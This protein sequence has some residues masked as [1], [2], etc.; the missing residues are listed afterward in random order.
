MSY[1]LIFFCSP[2]I[3]A[4]EVLC[5]E[6]TAAGLSLLV[7]HGDS[8]LKHL[9]PFFALRWNSAFPA[10]HFYPCYLLIPC[11]WIILFAFCWN[12][13]SFVG[14]FNPYYLLIPC[15]WIFDASSSPA[16]HQSLYASQLCPEKREK[17]RVHSE[18]ISCIKIH[19]HF[20]LCIV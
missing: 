14:Y 11:D 10:R 9:H 1:I 6:R 18:C 8:A 13:A 2:G 3:D 12:S 4:G 17:C 19:I 20:M 15:D 5:A 16:H 7:E